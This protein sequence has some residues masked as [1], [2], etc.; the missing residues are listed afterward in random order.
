ME[1]AMERVRLPAEWYRPSQIGMAAFLFY[2][3]FLYTVPASLSRLVVGSPAP[4]WLKVLAAVPLTVVAAYGLQLMGFVGHEGLHLS[5]HRNK[6]VSAIVGL[7]FA[8]A[9][10]SYLELGFAAQHWSHHRFTNQAGDPDIGPVKRLDTWWK[11]L[12]LARATYNVDYA[13][14]ALNLALGRPW[15]FRY[16]MPFRKAEVQRLAWVNFAFALVWL[17]AYVAITVRD[18]MTGLVSIALPMVT[19]LLLSGCQTF[20]DHA[21][22]G[23]EPSQCAWSRTSWLMSA[24]YFGA[25]YHLEHHLYP[26]VPCYRLH[27]VHRLLKEQGRLPERRVPHQPSF[28]RAYQAVDAPYEPAKRE[29]EFDPFI[30]A[31]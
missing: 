18:P 19:A 16:R 29:L 21:G 25:N 27:K 10:V 22:L 6:W 4:A 23:D 2:A 13:R 7:F 14:T 15:P 9:V 5:L 26:G 30:R 17:S 28:L 3:L 24:V 11:R 31:V 20:L 12:L 8:S 1:T